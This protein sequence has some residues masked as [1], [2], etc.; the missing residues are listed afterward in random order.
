VAPELRSLQAVGTGRVAD[1]VAGVGFLTFDA[2]GSNVSATLGTRPIQRAYVAKAGGGFDFGGSGVTG[3]EVVPYAMIG[4]AMGSAIPLSSATPSEIALGANGDGGALVGWGASGAVRGRGVNGTVAAG[5]AAFDLGITNYTQSFSISVIDDGSGLFAYAFSG[6]EGAGVTYQTAFGRATTTERAEDPFV[7]FSG[8][9]PVEVVQLAK[10]PSGYAL[11]IGAGAA[12]PFTGL[13]LLD[14][15]GNPTSISRLDGAVRALSIAVQGA[16]LGIAAIVATAESEAGEPLYAPE[17]RPFDSTGAP[18]G[19]WVCLQ[20][21]L[22]T[23]P[24]AQGVGLAADGTGYA[25]V[26]NANDGSVLLARFDHLGTG[27]Q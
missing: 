5:S 21:L 2:D 7:L 26:F 20:N 22:P 8:A 25:A 13:V 9:T 18:L 3:V 11:L 6:N 4:A 24:T 1:F 10:T 17:F 12:S 15:L 19:P 27:A 16:E 23:L 14:P